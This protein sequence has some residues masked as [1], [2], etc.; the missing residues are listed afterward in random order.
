MVPFIP[1]MLLENLC[2]K[3]EVVVMKIKEVLS[4]DVESHDFQPVI[5]MK[6]YPSPDVVES[7]VRSYVITDDVAENLYKFLYNINIYSKNP[8]DSHL[9]IWISGYY[10]S[11]KSHFANVVRFLI[12]NRELTDGTPVREFIRAKKLPGVRMSSEIALQ[13][14]ALKK[15]RKM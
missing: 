12:E 8:Q 7:I 13:I 11:G 10:G 2:G 5:Y 6:K 14:D 3:S 1:W 4:Y 15:K 9:G